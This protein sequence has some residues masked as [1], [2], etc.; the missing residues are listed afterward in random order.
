M[1][2][3]NL[4]R[5]ILNRLVE[6]YGK[7][8]VLKFVRHLNEELSLDQDKKREIL[9]SY[10]KKIYSI[11]VK[12]D[13][14]KYKLYYNDAAEAL[15][16]NGREAWIIEKVLSPLYDTAAEAYLKIDEMPN[17]KTYMQQVTNSYMMRFVKLLNL[18][19][20]YDVTS[21]S[22]FR[23]VFVEIFKAAM[24]EAKQEI[25]AK[26]AQEEEDADVQAGLDAK[27]GN[28]EDFDSANQ[29]K[30]LITTINNHAQKLQNSRY[31]HVAKAA[32]NYITVKT[33]LSE[34]EYIS[35]R[36]DGAIFFKTDDGETRCFNL[37]PKALEY[38]KVK[39]EESAN[40]IAS[41]CKTFIGDNGKY[42]DPSIDV[43]RPRTWLKR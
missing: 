6:S 23:Y 12:I 26:K 10:Y 3:V 30:D 35:L 37:S 18:P 34:V 24:G 17:F 7:T 38:L 5:A 19:D 31:S 1:N 28:F 9:D 11:F 8:D 29:G 16:S 43:T 40:L 41:W 4:D 33:D 39:D 20:S 36:T 25:E 2:N 21:N 13:G 27:P 15:R 22:S 32:E 14:G 42:V